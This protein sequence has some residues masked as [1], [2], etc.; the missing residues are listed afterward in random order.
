MPRKVIFQKKDYSKF[1]GFK[2]RKH[3]AIQLQSIQN[4]TNQKGVFYPTFFRKELIESAEKLSDKL[5]YD[6]RLVRTRLGHFYRCIL[7]RF[8]KFNGPLQNMI[9]A[10][11][12]GIKTFCVGYDL[13]EIIMK[14]GKSNISRIYQLYFYD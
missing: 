12:T 9:I 2:K 13:D 14:L 6:S 11:N 7:K 8:E 10:F 3:Q 5:E 4:I 1:I